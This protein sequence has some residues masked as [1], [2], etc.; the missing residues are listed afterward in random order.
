MKQGAKS[1]NDLNNVRKPAVFWLCFSCGFLLLSGPETRAQTRRNREIDTAYVKTFP[2]K[3]TGRTFLSQKYT[4]F[5]LSTPARSSTSLRFRPNSSLDLGVGATFKAFTL[6]LGYGL[7][8]LNNPEKGKTR[9]I[10]L[11]THVYLRKWVLDGFAQFYTGYYLTPRGNGLADPTRYYHR[12]DIGAYVVGGS[13]RRMFNF[14]RFSF[15]AALVQNEWQKKSAG[16]WLAGFQLHY[17]IIRGDSALVP[18]S[19]QTDFPIEAVRRMRFLKLGPGAGYAYTFV[20]REHFFATG[21]LT[22][23]LSATFSKEI[24]QP[25]QLTYGNVRPDLLFRAVAGY[26]SDKWCLT[27]SWINGSLSVQSPFYRYVIHT[28]NYRFTVARRFQ[29]SR[30]LQKLVP[31]TIKI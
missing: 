9:D 4:S 25:G 24:F 10:D 1:G 22:A 8:F 30:R 18:G 31:E 12:P 13:I 21:S 29:T 23:N 20:Y 11:Q 7:S 2:G 6:N 3:L 26:N 14:R 28:G 17:G 27:L 5:V 19:L 16:T 15:R